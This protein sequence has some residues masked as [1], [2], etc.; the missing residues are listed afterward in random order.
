MKGMMRK[1]AALALVALAACAGNPRG[2]GAGGDG[3]GGSLRVVVQ[4][5]GAIAAQVRVY[6]VPSSGAEI[7]LG[8]LSTLGTETLSTSAPMIQGSYVLR[9]VGGTNYQLTSPPIQLRG[10]ETITWDMRRNI[11]RLGGS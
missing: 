7:M 11:V 10:N 6:L 1:A 5:D 4:N 9:A 3:E 2:D 8:S